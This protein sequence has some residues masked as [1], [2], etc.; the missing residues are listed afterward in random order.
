VTKHI[1]SSTSATIYFDTCL[2]GAVVK[3]DHPAEMPALTALLREHEAG[4]LSIV[5]STEVLG[6]IERVPPQYQGAHLGVLSQ[7][8]RLPAANVRWINE[9]M[10]SV[11]S[12]DED[13]ERLRHILP[14]ETDRR[15][16]VHA[17]K[18]HVGYFATVDAATILKH[19]PELEA[20]FSLRFATPSDI[21]A[22]LRVPA[23]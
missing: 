6:E 17:I 20:T 3:G 19:R 8:R 1:L 21:V 5:A 2:V 4:R 22:E 10:P 12:T 14:G 18:N 13:Y 11:L 16:V 23:T 15:H 7:L 9:A